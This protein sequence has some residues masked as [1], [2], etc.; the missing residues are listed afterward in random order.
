MKNNHDKYLQLLGWS[1]IM[2]RYRLKDIDLQSYE[3]LDI[4]HNIPFLLNDNKKINDDIILD[5]LIRYENN[6]LNW[7]NKYSSIITQDTN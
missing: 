4:I 5:D 3:L 7:E 2:L 1:I 6:Y